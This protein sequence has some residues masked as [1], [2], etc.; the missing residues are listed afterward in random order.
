M[1]G[2]DHSGGHKIVDTVGQRGQDMVKAMQY[3]YL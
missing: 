1:S 2:H 3:V